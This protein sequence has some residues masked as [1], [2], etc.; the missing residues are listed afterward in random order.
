MKL[1][2]YTLLITFTTTMVGC[3]R[4][5]PV[6]DSAS[7]IPT[8]Q[9]QSSGTGVGFPSGS[10]LYVYGVATGGADQSDAFANGQTVQLE[11]GNGVVSAELAATTS[12]TNSF[13][14]SNPDHIIGGFGVSC[15]NYAQGFYGVNPGPGPN[16]EASVQFTLSAPAMV[17]VIGLASSQKILTL[18][19]LS[20]P[21]IDVPVQTPGIDT[22]ADFLIIAHQYLPAGSYTIQ[23]TSA[24]GFVY[25]TPNHEADLL[26]VLIFSDYPF[27]VRSTYPPI[28]LPIT[29]QSPASQISGKILSSSGQPIV[30]ASVQIGSASTTSASDGTFSITGL[31]ADNYPVIVTAS[32]YTTLTTSLVVPASSATEQN[33][34]LSPISSTPSD[35]LPVVTSVTTQYSPN[36]ET[37]Y[38]LDGV[39][40]PVTF[41]A[42]VNWGTNSPGT[43]NFITPTGTYPVNANGGNTV[44]QTIDVGT[45]FWPGGKLQVQAVSSNGT[46]SVAVV[47]P[48]VVL[49]LPIILPFQIVLEANHYSYQSTLGA[50]FQFLNDF[51]PPGV[52]VNSNIPFFGDN[53]LGLEYNPSLSATLQDNEVKF[54]LQVSSQLPTLP[55]A[56]T[57]LDLTPQVDIFG[58]YV[59]PPAQWQWGGG[60]GLNA[61]LSIS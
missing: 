55:I 42:T 21:T 58:T 48:V 29:P 6:I 26:G 28:P 5:T 23:G 44:S 12:N 45:A 11:D 43:V 41:T 18:S 38:F 19:G 14:T 1:K 51:L 60:V 22:G 24:D 17:V 9:D 2:T 7:S 53:P 27:A 54:I 10:E 34:T 8:W 3:C 33:F 37:L 56:G 32:A 50:N 40:F 20:N 57:E 47:A 13:S 46:S 16:L 61:N 25:A 59:S 36:G 52:S 35:G 49:S 39:A 15:F 4:A 31:S 30:G